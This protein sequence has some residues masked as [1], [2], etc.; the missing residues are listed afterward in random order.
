MNEHLEDELINA[1]ERMGYGIDLNYLRGQIVINT[2]TSRKQ[3]NHVFT[4]LADAL[5]WCKLRE[6][7]LKELWH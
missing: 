2:G 7:T 1:C 3:V 4:N 6:S 5:A